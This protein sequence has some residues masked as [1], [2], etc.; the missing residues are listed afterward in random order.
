MFLITASAFTCTHDTFV[1]SIQGLFTLKRLPPLYPWHVSQTM[2]LNMH[3]ERNL[4]LPRSA[5]TRFHLFQLP[6]QKNPTGILTLLSHSGVLVNTL[7][8]S[9]LISLFG[10][11]CF[12]SCIEHSPGSNLFHL[13][14]DWD[15]PKVALVSPYVSVVCP[16]FL[17]VCIW[18]IRG[19]SWL[20]LAKVHMKLKSGV[21][22]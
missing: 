20:Y 19:K 1:F 5:R 4:A 12:S 16:V 6:W 14:A 7:T 21:S 22:S 8:F 9:L 13:W 2:A 3:S 10:E 17:L 11:T 15:Q 18:F